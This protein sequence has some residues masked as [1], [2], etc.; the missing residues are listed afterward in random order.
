VGME[1]VHSRRAPDLDGKRTGLGSGTRAPGDGH[2]RSE[3]GRMELSVMPPRTALAQT[4]YCLANRG[5]EYLVY[6]P[7]AGTFWVD[8]F[9]GSGRTF[10]VEWINPRTGEVVPGGGVL[11]GNARQ[12]F[13]SPL[14]DAGS[15][16]YLKT[17][18]AITA[19]CSLRPF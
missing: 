17:V 4:A 16:L 12:S 11:G 10:V 2:A 9:G 14:N 3:A 6:A 1:V 19:P 15:M 5:V 18:R 8:L 13:S 7:D